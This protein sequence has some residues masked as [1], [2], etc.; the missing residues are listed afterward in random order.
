MKK[1]IFLILLVIIFATACSSD[2]YDIAYNRHL[3]KFHS[4]MC[5]YSYTDAVFEQLIEMINNKDADKLRDSYA[6][7]ISD[8]D[9]AGFDT[10]DFLDYFDGKII[11]YEKEGS[12]IDKRNGGLFSNYYSIYF[13]RSYKIHT[14]DESY[15]LCY[16]YC[17]CSG[18]RTEEGLHSLGVMLE[19]LDDNDGRLYYGI[20]GIYIC[21]EENKETI[22]A[23]AKKYGAVN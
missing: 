7:C 21:T 16:S 9:I 10:M 12:R 22:Q 3:N 6:E 13:I 15:I 20:P 2:E 1:H 8:I 14:E 23:L 5:T 17:F 19:D 11:S 4:F 18:D